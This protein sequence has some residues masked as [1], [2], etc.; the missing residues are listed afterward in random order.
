MKPAKL[1]QRLCSAPDLDAAAATLSI[2]EL[3]AVAEYIA[4]LPR[5]GGVPAQIGGVITAK[6]NELQTSQS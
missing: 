2:T 1:Y 6:I 4:S 3:A 5:G